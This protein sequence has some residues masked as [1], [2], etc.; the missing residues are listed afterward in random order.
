MDEPSP[1][2]DWSAGAVRLLTEGQDWPETGRPRRAGV[3]SFG[4]SGTNA[5]VILEGAEAGTEP[6]RDSPDP[7]LV[8]C[9]LSARGEA[10]LRAQALRLADAL[11][12]DPVLR[13]VDVAALAT[14]TR[15]E[16]RAVVIA[17][18]RVDLLRGL[19]A[20][21]RGEVAANV[22]EGDTSGRDGTDVSPVF[23]FP[24][25]GTQSVGMAV[26]LLDTMPSFDESLARCER[27]L[28]PFVDWSVVD[29]LRGADAPSLDRVDVV[30]PV[31]WAVMV[32]LADLWGTFGVRPAAVVGHS[33]GEVAA[34]TVAGALSLEDAARVVAMRSRAVAGLPGGAGMVSVARPADEVR[35][36][37]AK[38]LPNLTI[39]AV[40]GPNAVVVAGAVADLDDLLSVCAARGIRA[41]R[42]AVDYAS[43]TKQ[44]EQL[45]AGLLDVLEPVRPRSSPIPF[46]S[47]VTAE[48]VDT[49]TLD[50]EYWYRNLRA[51]VRFDEA[52]AT[53][54]RHGHRAFI[55][56]S[57]HPVLVSAI[58][59]NVEALPDSVDRDQVVV[60]KTLSRDAEDL[61]QFHLSVAEAHVRGIRADP[62][63]GLP[64]GRGV[65]E[66]P[67]YPF[68]RRRYW[69]EPAVEQREQR[70][71]GADGAFWEAVEN[72][73]LATLTAT[74][75]VAGDEPLSAVLPALARWREN[76]QDKTVVDSWRYRV[77]W[78]RLGESQPTSLPG[79]WLVVTADD[80]AF[81]ELAG[82]R[83]EGTDIVAV[84]LG[85]QR[86]GRDEVAERLR[87]AT[88]GR[89]LAGVI[90]ALT[91]DEE[92]VG[93][94]AAV[95]RG[96]A[97]TV[98]LIQAL[99][100]VGVQAPLWC[101]TRGAVATD[102]TE[103]LPAPAQA[104]VWGLS[105]VMG[106]EHPARWGGVIDLPPASD[107]A[108][109]RRLVSAVLAEDEDQL[110][111]RSSGVHAR[112]LVR[113]PLDGAATPSAWQPSG[114]VLI[115]GGTG[116]LGAHVARWLARAGAEHLVLTS[117]GGPKSPGATELAA[118][119]EGSGCAVTIAACDA[120][121]RAAVRRLLAGIP[122]HRPLTAVVHAA[123]VLDDA[124]IEAL[125]FEQIDRVLHAKMT[126][127][128]NLHE[129]TADLELRAFVLFSSAGATFGVPGQGNY[130]PANAF[131]DAL[132]QHRRAAGL[133]ATS[134]GWG[135]WQ[136]SGM[137]TGAVRTLLDRHGVPAIDTRL[138][139][140]AL[141][142]ALAHDEV[143]ALVADVRWDRYFVAMT[144]VRP[145]PLFHDVPEVAAL[146]EAGE[147][148][149]DT[150]RV[151]PS[152][153]L[154]LAR[155]TDAERGRAWV[156]LVCSHAA[157]VLG[158][159][160][161]EAVG[162]RRTFTEAGLDS[163]L[164]VELRNRLAHATGLSLSAPVV[165]DHPTPAA[166]AAHLGSRLA[167]EPAGTT[168]PPP[169]AAQA[170]E[171]VAIIGLACRY[172][173]GVGSAEELWQLLVNG[174]EALSD[175]PAGRGWPADAE[176]RSGTGARVRIA[177]GA[178]GFLH[179]AADFDAGLFGISPREALAMDPQQRLLLETSWEVLERGGIDPTS[180]R[181][182]QTSVFV[183]VAGS[184]YATVLRVAPDSTDGHLMTGNA[185]SVVAGRVS[186]AFG[187]EGPAV[188]VD[189]ACSSSLVAMHLAAQSLRNGECTLAL[190]GGVT[191]MSTPELLAEFSRQG[192][193]A[194][195][196]RCKSF[197]EG[198]DGTGLGEGAGI[199]LLE[200]LSDAR[201]NGRRVLAVLRGSAVN[202]DGASNG[203]TAPSGPAQQRVIRAALANAGLESSDVDAVEAH[204]TGT[205]LGDPIEAQAL[206]ATY[207]QGRPV[208]RPLWL[209]SVKSNIGHTQ[210]AA[211]VA[212][213]IKMVMAL[214]HGRLPRTLHVDEPSSHVDWSAGAV[215]LLTGEQD[216]PETGRPRRA[217]VSSF[218]ISGTNAHVIVEQAPDD[219]DDDVDDGQPFELPLVP[220]VLSGRTEAAMRAAAR[221]LHEAVAA[222]PGLSPVDIGFTTATTRSAMEHRGVVLAADRADLLAGL[223]ALADRRRTQGTLESPAGDG[224]LAFGFPGQ[225]E[226]HAGVGAQLHA[227]FPVFADA[228]DEVCGLFDRWL[229]EPLAAVMFAGPESPLADRTDYA[230]AGALALGVGLF[231]LLGSWG[232]APDYVMGH[233]V[234][235][236]VAGCVSGLLP[237]ADAVTLVAARGR[238]MRALPP[239]GVMVSV[240]AT[241]DEVAPLLGD[242]VS[243][244]A[245]NGPD[246]VVLS[247]DEDTV[248]ALADRFAGRRTKRLRVA[249]AFHSARMEGMLAE[250]RGVAAGL[251]FGRGAIPVVSTV[252]GLVATAEELADP[253]HWVRN[254]RETVRFADTV[255]ALAGL[256]VDRFLE[257]GPTGVL[258]AM[259]AACAQDR[260]AFVPA[261]RDGVAEPE[262]VVRG[263]AELHACGASVDW[264]AFFAGTGARRVDLPTYP[265]Q[266]R[267][268][269]P[270]VPA[271][272]GGAAW[273][274][275]V[276]WKPVPDEHEPA[277]RGA[278][279]FVTPDSRDTGWATRL[280]EGM[281]DRGA[282]VLP[283]PMSE[284]GSG[285]TTLAKR[286]TA[287]A[288]HTTPAGVLLA[289]PGR[290]HADPG[291]P[292]ADMTLLVQALGDAGIESPLWCVTAGAASV[293]GTDPVVDA[294]G[295]QL[296]GL[297]RVVAL[298][299]PSRWGGLVDLPEL[300]GENTIDRLV[301]ALCGT[302]GEDQLAVRPSGLHARRLVPAGAARSEVPDGRWVSG[303]VLVTGG[304]GALGARVARWLADRGAEHLVLVGRR[305]VD[306]PGAP[307]LAAGLAASGVRVTI[308]ACDA[309]DRA[310]LAA[311]I[312]AIP[313]DCPLTAVVHAAGVLANAPVDA[314]DADRVDE[315]LDVKVR[316]ATN[317]HD[318]TKSHDL[319]AFVLF[320][321]I[322]GVWGSG[323]QG[324]YAAANAFLDA[325]ASRR[326]AEGL[327]ATSIAWGAWD[328][329]GMSRGAP[330]EWLR[331]RGIIPMAP[332]A[333]MRELG[334]ALDHDETFVVVADVDWTR[335]APS[336]TLNRRQPLIEDLP[337]VRDLAA[338]EGT[339]QDRRDAAEA[340]PYAKRL[341][342]LSADERAHALVELVRD[343]MVRVLGH[344]HTE[345]ISADRAFR[346]LGFDSLTAVEMRT[347]LSAATGLKL[348][349][350]VVFDH[351]TPAALA[352]YLDTELGAGA[353]VTDLPVLVQIDA[354][355]AA[356]A[357]VAPRD[358]AR[359][360]ITARLRH[361]LLAWGDDP[362]EESGDS[363]TGHLATA[364]DE[365]MFDFINRELG[366]S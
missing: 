188:T 228:F 106:L 349:A 59:E 293:D 339:R 347:E 160:S 121:D 224:L 351:P 146:R 181:G 108:A 265:F 53:L 321:S 87:E 117:R 86:L 258:S 64:V 253:E 194:G 308:A 9:L 220:C 324:L 129:L 149:R 33:Q 337:Q 334:A 335:F 312:D 361:L 82:L 66:L 156:E 141:R 245:V 227:R 15:F 38:R 138:A 8:P 209:G 131:L 315:V 208:D 333:A 222:D 44:V 290:N 65:A 221:R 261:I 177:T 69:L 342:G 128:L 111:V 242:G 185:T 54:A 40:N 235:E 18:D 225:G 30:Q 231:R 155:L 232:V 322:A 24:G 223:D 68:Q 98:A 305:G 317:L 1:H 199:V 119:L 139:I 101:V 200:R 268:Y 164:A 271:A 341:A 239:G 113:A 291:R 62:A 193:L 35:R 29:V 250:F 92:R 358:T 134:I 346:E 297:G 323:N 31:L 67:T 283:L 103:P 306:A 136:G 259:G 362:S 130:A 72:A 32:A 196:G 148:D 79:T 264:P 270:T 207:G 350:T 298:E 198:A 230:Q 240:Q 309:A 219:A 183:G 112:R 192:G 137:A 338:D 343:T 126:A 7:S 159:D 61:R 175:L 2:V 215:E 288:A 359:S 46:C 124:V 238:L 314:V 272:T 97:N 320:S 70:A 100:D 173:G 318:L 191:I 153:A 360:K 226:R 84:S 89:E 184:D 299:H 171:P 43:H 307:E 310:A 110:A 23:V 172:P 357:G 329:G 210:A 133:P 91:L 260:V 169:D 282:E 355:E 74:L 273:R 83:D 5:H 249:H 311:V 49:A 278:W 345:E 118:E 154:R 286:L 247:G 201:R 203:L 162:S 52:I 206:L 116:A 190:A 144:A 243:L 186:Y 151:E 234:G 114:T 304:T 170:G 85:H 336:F 26:G 145:S 197:A 303:T 363:L 127:A 289:V 120:G 34:A 78:T 356:L 211:G 246:S 41:R 285:R 47:G 244:A 212:G 13:P 73:D 93:P 202:Q 257:L 294:V 178:G 189:T 14:R 28:A 327:P 326:R 42:I 251:S 365:E 331:R 279:L 80:Q 21:A 168:T 348:P 237:V 263:V 115:T 161:P 45:R 287:I 241:E 123:G 4:V 10:A 125:T 81:G 330:A 284:A 99:G 229:D 17:E 274:Y 176:Y 63:A 301:Q 90:S 328:G 88:G 22:V 56:V 57:A 354:L 292:V 313:D 281:A 102:A 19:S 147:A 132:A 213:V 60:T 77:T 140:E 105:R 218:G 11:G 325:L 182:S 262:S 58:Q 187:F 254:V 165:F 205:T 352:V 256:G 280:A 142:Q 300:V 295:A 353:A 248:S 214:R 266:R 48:L 163:V 55:E 6:A 39:A 217:G 25:Q 180:L 216:W 316:A 166:L 179:D 20:L 16:H 277:L 50:G 71:G 344:D 107:R 174:R 275:R 302:S 95:P 143:H 122:S 255:D 135:A 340:P 364:T 150:N 276:G 204:G 296:W 109:L 252:T 157:V 332:E 12:E 104:L 195:D 267:R 37:L 94:S 269:W 27:A 319:T 152:F 3:S 158:H 233:S 36:L 96:F 76:S 167:N 236:V 366:A 75:G 51:P